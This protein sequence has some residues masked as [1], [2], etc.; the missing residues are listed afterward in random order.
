MI[1]DFTEPQSRQLSCD[2]LAVTLSE[3]P[4]N[5]PDTT[6]L[7][8]NHTTVNRTSKKMASHNQPFC[9]HTTV[10]RT[11]KKLA[12]HN[13]PFCNHT[14]VNRTSKKL[15]SHNQT[16]CSHTSAEWQHSNISQTKESRKTEVGSGFKSRMI[17][18]SWSNDH[19]K[20]CESKVCF[21]PWWQRSGVAWRTSCWCQ[22]RGLQQNQSLHSMRKPYMGKTPVDTLTQFHKWIHIFSLPSLSISLS[23]R[24]AGGKSSTKKWRAVRKY[25]KKKQERKKKRKSNTPCH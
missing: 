5:W 13:Q 3:P 24:Q 17:D 15:A 2:H 22:L 9:N 12:S 8:C 1:V 21:I 23:E 25:A 14:T 10:N 19:C 7:F 18:R 16:F 20:G 4:K 11:S 6:N